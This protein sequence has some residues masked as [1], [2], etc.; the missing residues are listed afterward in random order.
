MTVARYFL[1]SNIWLY[2]LSDDNEIKAAVA[3]KLVREFGD[4]ICFTIQ[5]VNEVCFNLK[6]KSQVGEKELRRLIFSFFLH[7]RFIDVSES[8]LISA[9]DM[10]ERYSLSFWDSIIVSSAFRDGAEIL[11]SE[12]MQDGLLIEN[13]LKIVNPFIP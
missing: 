1:D 4:E 8:I 11:Y 6:R 12:D 2:A 10:R 13:R 3:R 7:Y 5:I 9:S